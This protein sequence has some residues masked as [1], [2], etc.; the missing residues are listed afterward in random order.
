MKIVLPAIV[1][2][3]LLPI[4]MPLL[5]VGVDQNLLSSKNV[6][7]NVEEVL[8]VVDENYVYPEIAEAMRKF[9]S[10]ELLDGNYKGIRS[11]K[12][13]ITKLQSDLR[14]VSKDNHIS[15][16]LAKNALDRNTHIQPIVKPDDDFYVGLVSEKTDRKKVG[17]LRFDKFS[18][19]VS[20]KNRVVAAMKELEGTDSL[21]IDLRENIG[22][23]P[24][25]VA[26]L[27]SYFLD[28]NTHLWSILDRNGKTVFEVNSA[29]QEQKYQGNLCLLTSQKTYSA[30]EAFVYT[31]KHLGR[32]CIFGEATG[33]GAHL[34]QMERVNDEIDI[35]IPVARAYNPI[36]K[37]NWEGTGVIPT[38]N[39]EASQ[40]KSAAVEYFRNRDN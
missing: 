38:V 15:L 33:G 5:A 22:G 32:A 14:A 20:T 3:T 17:Y 37:S 21:I 27:S 28:K 29:D 6:Q 16:H 30:A 35:R 26:F 2:F 24:N 39:V 11:H 25:L 9:V 40:A 10:K 4:I 13:L 12:A 31:L 19:D 36:T 8:K 34:V 1:L 18:G 23:D 7:T